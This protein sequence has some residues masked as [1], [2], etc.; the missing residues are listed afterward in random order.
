M[1]GW[2][3]QETDAFPV[4]ESKQSYRRDDE[5]SICTTIQPTGRETAFVFVPHFSS[6]VL[7]F[8]RHLLSLLIH[9]DHRDL[10]HQ[11]NGYYRHGGISFLT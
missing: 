6:A 2:T 4:F 5:D 1:G 3:G 8:L 7:F 10:F 11:A 9:L